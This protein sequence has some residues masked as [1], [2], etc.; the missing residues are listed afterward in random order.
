MTA[1]LAFAELPSAVLLLGPGGWEAGLELYERHRTSFS[2]RVNLLDAA[3]ARYVCQQAYIRPVGKTF[4]IYLI[5]LDGASDQA[6]NILLKVLE[7]PPATV[8]FIL[9]S[10]LAP[11]D[12]IVS[13]CQVLTPAPPEAVPDTARTA[14]QSLV[15]A[16]VRGARDGQP[17]VLETALRRWDPAHTAVLRAWAAERAAD[18]WVQFDK[19]FVPGVTVR[20]ALVILQVLRTYEGGRTAP[21]VALMKAFGSV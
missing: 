17:Q 19:D 1:D 15:A 6:Q 10:A 3:N 2:G 11:L 21:A 18:R 16:A 7:E 5:N 13:R 4:R 12:T 8:R 9:T 14:E 20:Q